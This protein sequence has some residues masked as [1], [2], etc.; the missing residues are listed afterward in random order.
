MCVN[1]DK[2]VEKRRPHDKP[3]SFF[4]VKFEKCPLANYAAIKDWPDS[5]RLGSSSY[6]NSNLD[7]KLLDLEQFQVVGTPYTPSCRNL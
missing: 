1:A 7:L 4:V 2:L 3:L 5:T 6:N